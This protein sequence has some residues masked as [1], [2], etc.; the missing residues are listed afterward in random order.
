MTL[1]G[2]DPNSIPPGTAAEPS[3]TPERHLIPPDPA[4]TLE[5]LRNAGYTTHT[6]VADLIDNSLAGGATRVE[7]QLYQDCGRWLLEIADDGHGMTR[8]A[9]IEAM[10]LSARSTEPRHERDLG[11]YGIGMKAAALHLSGSG[12]MEIDTR[13]AT[14]DGGLTGWSLD[15]VREEGW[16][17]EVTDSLR[18]THGTTVIIPDPLVA[19][20]DASGHLA[21]LWQH[22]SLV[23]A[24]QAAQDVYLSVQ[25]RRVLPVDVLGE[26]MDGTRLRGPWPLDEGRVN[27]TGYILP[28]TDP[29]GSVPGWFPSRTDLSGLHLRRGGR[30]ITHGGWTGLARKGHPPSDRV[31]L[32]VE[33]RPEDG[34][35]WGVDLTKSRMVIPADLLHRLQELADDLVG[36]AQRMRGLRQDAGG[37]PHP[38][39]AAPG[40][41]TIWT[42]DGHIDRNHPVAAWALREG[43]DAVKRLFEEL[44]RGGA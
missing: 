21:R 19:G 14:G 35:R 28:P 16:T 22:L 30:A 18:R 10:R 40:T 27:V 12:R 15:S 2:T 23:F 29:D 26:E 42:A 5:G 13:T 39:P 32:L 25:G 1:P 31:R 11:R 20:E 33:I 8:D 17:I 7:V 3:G 37:S 38:V 41:G 36:R 6:A 9:L 4:G 43:G 24:V 44:E 34:D